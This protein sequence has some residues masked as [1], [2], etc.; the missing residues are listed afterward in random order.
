M[1]LRSNSLSLGGWAV[2]QLA[3]VALALSGGVIVGCSMI[4]RAP[5]S[6]EQVAT[7]P[8]DE[9]NAWLESAAG[10]SAA[11][12]YSAVKWGGASYED[13]ERFASKLEQ[14]GFAADMFEAA[15][16]A[17]ELVRNPIVDQLLREAQLLVDLKRELTLGHRFAEWATRVRLALL[18]GA[19]RARSEAQR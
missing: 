6:L 10:W 9:W 3:V 19:L 8:A 2:A 16:D 11:A 14:R 12:G 13:L 15:A 4:R 17:A 1:R 7:M 18:D 5:R